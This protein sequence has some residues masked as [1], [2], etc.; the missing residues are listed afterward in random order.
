VDSEALPLTCG[1]GCAKCRV[2]SEVAVTYILLTGVD[3]FSAAVKPW[4]HD[5]H[6]T[7]TVP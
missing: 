4:L 1:R 3:H 5:R 2:L 6:A 7:P